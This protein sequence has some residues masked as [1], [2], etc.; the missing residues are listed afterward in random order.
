M[1]QQ[2]KA[3]W[4]NRAKRIAVQP[5]ERSEANKKAMTHP[6]KTQ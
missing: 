2:C 1:A 4:R 5:A 3:Q 6:N